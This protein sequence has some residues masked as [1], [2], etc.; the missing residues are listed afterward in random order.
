M[1]IYYGKVKLSK[2]GKKLDRKGE[3]VGNF[4]LLVLDSNANSVR[5]L[6]TL[7]LHHSELALLIQV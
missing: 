5:V 2:V 6:T 7:Q 4:L 1:Y 3:Q